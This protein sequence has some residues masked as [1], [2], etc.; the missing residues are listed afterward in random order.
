MD[1]GLSEKQELHEVSAELAEV[2]ATALSRE[3][4][5]RG[6]FESRLTSAIAVCGALL[7][8]A[9]ALSSSASDL[10]IHGAPKVMFSI[11]FSAA[12]VLLVFAILLFVTAI[13]PNR[14]HVANIERIKA[15][16]KPG[17][18]DTQ[19]RADGFRLDVALLEQI[20]PQ[21]TRRA[22]HLL[23]GQYCLIAALVAAAGG[24]LDIFFA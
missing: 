5:D 19:P 23:Y 9:F 10:K 1:A 7:A 20:R 12:V 14:V 21:N 16:A 18:P 22:K 13:Q 15:L 6:S 2:T 24:A 17:V 8:A 11:A 3:L 4:E